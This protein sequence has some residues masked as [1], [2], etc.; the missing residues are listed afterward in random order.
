M[1][2]AKQVRRL[3]FY[4]QMLERALANGWLNRQMQVLVVCGGTL[5]RDAF[6]DAE[7]KNVTISN[8]SEKRLGEE[9]AAPYRWS[10]QDAEN[11]TFQDEEFDFVVVHDGLHHCASPHR[12][13]LEMYRVAKHGIMVF[14]SRDSLLIRLGKML[15]F[16]AEYELAPVIQHGFL[17]GG[18]RNTGIPNYVYRWKEDEVVKTIASYDPRGR[19]NVRFFYGLHLPYNRLT[20]FNRIGYWLAHALEPVVRG[21]HLLFPK[22]CN[23]FAFVAFK[24]SGPD[25]MQPWFKWQDEDS[26]L[27]QDWF[28]RKMRSH[29]SAH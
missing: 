9:G 23:R 16:A 12:G 28:K 8:L 22:Q 14:E 2:S 17:S 1:K 10:E 18:F 29:A 7:F 20:K 26:V 5:D 27:D 19:V 11:L 4:T 21:I 24:P 3:G 6:L 13:M 25:D 15:G